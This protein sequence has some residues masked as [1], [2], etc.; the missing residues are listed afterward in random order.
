MKVVSRIDDIVQKALSNESRIKHAYK[1]FEDVYWNWNPEK[2]MKF[3]NFI[4][5]IIKEP[6]SVVT[7]IE[8]RWSESID[9]YSKRIWDYD[10]KV[11]IFTS[12]EFK[13]LLR[14]ITKDRINK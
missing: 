9:W 13:W 5:W 4:S 7:T 8:K 2:G 10:Y 12:W 11:D 1:H 6:D 3:K 14:T